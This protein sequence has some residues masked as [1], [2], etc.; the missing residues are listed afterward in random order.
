MNRK[1]KITL[2]GAI[3][4]ILLYTIMLLDTN[5]VVK[6]VKNIM[7]GNVDEAI[8]TN[9]PLSKYNF[10]SVLQNAEVKVQITRLAVIHNFFD[11]Y[12]WVKYSYETIKNDN[13]LMPGSWDVISRWKIHRENGGWE[14]VEI[15]EAP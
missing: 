3:I 9:T 4:V 10:S 11:G 14:I 15:T 2:I 12:M 13:D 5:S 6:D 1:I 7:L 8:T